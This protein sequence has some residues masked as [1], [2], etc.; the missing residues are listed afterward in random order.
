MSN[1]A[2]IVLCAAAGVV[3]LAS[4]AQAQDG[5]KVDATTSV[6]VRN[7]NDETTVVTPRVTLGAPL[8]S[9]TRLDLTYTVD[10]WTS[11]SVDIRT[12]AS[13]RAGETEPEPVTEQR[14]EI[15][16]ALE[17]A[18]TDVTLGGSYRYSTENDY[19]SHG[20]SLGAS[21]DFADN[22][23][24][25]ALTLRA[26]FDQVG[27]AGTPDFER[28]A[29]LYLAR[30]AF[31]Q[32][33]DPQMV[34]QLVYELG[35]QQGYLSSP[36]RYVRFADAE[37]NVPATCGDPVRLCLPENS[38]ESRI[39]HAIA[40]SARRSLSDTLSLGANYRFYIDDWDMVSHTIGIDGALAPGSGWL[41]ALGYR[42]YRQNSASHYKP[43][44]TTMPFPEH[45][46][47]DKELSALTSHRLE[48]ELE[49]AWGLDALGSELKLVLLAAGTRFLYHEFPLLDEVLAV[50]G[51]LAVEVSL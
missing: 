4:A 48:L 47:S 39:K 51:T 44:Y 17:H 29:R 50:E 27:R 7:D 14:D 36:Y 6:Y 3:A 21:Y 18:F 43:F 35:V 38:P 25:L 22:N 34:A 46:T 49:K 2:R 24:K 40:L 11:A 13:L 5:G 12:S 1:R 31:T 33:I 9:E 20:A 41:L 23:A 19:E 16:V 30:T 15:D 8:G 26:Y 45:F 10:V 28:D 37:G 32:V 42:L